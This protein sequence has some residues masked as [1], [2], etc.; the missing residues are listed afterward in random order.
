MGG[1]LVVGTE[2]IVLVRD[3]DGGSGGKTY[4]GNEDMEMIET[5][6]D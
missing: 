6:T 3:A 2:H 5:D 4:R 1:Q